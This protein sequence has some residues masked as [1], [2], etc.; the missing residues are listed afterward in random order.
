MLDALSLR[1]MSKIEQSLSH[2]FQ[3]HRLVFWYDAEQ[4]LNQEFEELLLEDVTKLVVAN[5]EF[6]LKHLMMR[7]QPKQKFLIY[8]PYERPSTQQNWLLDLELASKVFNAD[9]K[10]LVLQEMGLEA[11]DR[12]FIEAYPV[13]FDK[14]SNSEKLAKLLHKDD[15][16]QDRCL[17]MLSVLC[18]TEPLMDE[19]LIKLFSESNGEVA[20]VSPL[21]AEIEKCGLEKDLWRLIEKHYEISS[22]TQSVMDLLVEIFELATPLTANQPRHRHRLASVFLNRW[23]DSV[24]H[25]KGFEK[26]S[27][28]V[29]LITHPLTILQEET[30]ILTLNEFDNYEEIDQKII[31]L[32]REGLLNR[33]IPLEQIKETIQVRTRSFWYERYHHIYKC[34]EQAAELNDGLDRSDFGI[35]SYAQA[36]TSYTKS[37]YKLDG[38]YRRMLYHQRSAKQNTL[39]TSLTKQ[40]QGRYLNEF[41]YK[42]NQRV[43]ETL[44]E[45]WET[46][47]MPQRDFFHEHVEPFLTNG[48]KLFVVI[49][50]ALR[51]EVGQELMTRVLKEDKYQAKLSPML[52]SLPSYTQLG[53]ASLLPNNELTISPNDGSARVNG[54]S[55]SGIQARDS[56]LKSNSGVTAGCIKM[57]E[58]L[59]M[60]RDETRD[61]AKE[62]DLVYIYHNGIDAVGDKRE[63]EEK[64]PDAVETEICKLMECMKKVAGANRSNLLIT[65]DHG[66]FYQEEPPT[67]ASFTAVD[68]SKLSYVNRR[69][70]LSEEAEEIGAMHCYDATA[71][72]L[73][74]DYSIYLPKGLQMLKV[75]GSGAR[76]IHGGASLQE[77]VIPVLHINIKRENDLIQTEV[78]LI[79]TGSAKVTTTEVNVRLFQKSAIGEKVIPRALRLGFYNLEGESISEQK[80]LVFDSTEE[81]ARFR[82]QTASLMLSAKADGSLNQEIYLRLTEPVKGSKHTKPYLEYPFTYQKAFTSDFEAF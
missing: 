4:D 47:L 69:F 41:A 55:A 33:S 67:E 12:S 70:A 21:Y 79:R 75:Q 51:Y 38:N 8:L 73:T 15:S 11:E 5:N 25:S 37:W 20:D 7:E 71:L 72:G 31:T 59:A 52:S 28:A 56:I 9:A 40:S 43:S 39:L 27:K 19:V 3:Q 18:K 13:F 50:D 16:L 29:S 45:K 10:S 26:A 77:T 53:M 35:D 54:I 1:Q 64:L 30:E 63:T 24:K 14:K 58:F 78:D 46:Q 60:S 49:S 44:P 66:F 74:G 68:K 62:N 36:L 80:D 82:E 34:L 57:E 32:L 6:G 22:E 23:K 76:F 48:G 65:S 61:L 81:D 42:V 2:L 17:K